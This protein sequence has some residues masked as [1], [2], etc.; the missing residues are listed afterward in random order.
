MQAKQANCQ[1]QQRHSQQEG[2]KELSILHPSQ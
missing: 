1:N 2:L